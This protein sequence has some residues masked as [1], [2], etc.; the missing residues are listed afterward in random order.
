MNIQKIYNVQFNAVRLVQ[1]TDKSEPSF[2]GIQM[3]S[4][5]TA[6]TV[7]F[8]GRG[9][10]VISSELRAVYARKE[11]R[12]LRD[13]RQITEARITPDKTAPT[14][15]VLS[16]EERKGG[17]SIS[18]SQKI[19]EQVL[20]PQAQ[21]SMFM[22]KIFGD[23]KVSE[24]SPK[25]VILDIKDRAK[26]VVSIMEKSATRGWD[27]VKEVLANMTDLN[28]AKIVMNHKTGKEETET[29][30]DR[31]I[32]LIK[33]GQI[34]LKEIEL[35]RPN[36]IKK[37]TKK[38]QEEYDYVST[39]FLNRLE[40]IQEEVWNGLEADVDN[41]RLVDRPLPKHTKGNYCALH[42][43]LQLKEKGSRPFELQ[44]MGARMD[45]G[46]CFDD[47]RFKFFDGKQLDKKYSEL[48]NLWEPL[49]AEEN[50]G[51]KERFLQYCKDANLQLRKDEL[52]ENRTQ[53][54]INRHTGFFKT[55]RDY[56]LPPEYD[57]NEQFKIMQ[58]CE[59]AHVTDKTNKPAKSNRNNIKKSEDNIMSIEML[60]KLVERFK[61]KSFEK[62]KG[63]KAKH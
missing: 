4:P 59:S 47:K 13:V 35:Q 34:E 56:N 40:D 29:V 48:I 33:T 42:F 49:K 3:K 28:G 63:T 6:D 60:S 52:Q 16:G 39:D 23:L 11:A 21:I 12:A 41:I 51:A 53:K 46:K 26:S 55:V 54:L 20:E 7:S 27:S 24:F 2:I 57:L 50:E 10:K 62:N 5:L 44:I 30:L 15:K 25:N 19:R 32:P 61:P 36:A 37:L 17:V 43:I 58:K 9:A 8:R 18:V 45:R 1:K 38:E 22:N 14:K 31:L